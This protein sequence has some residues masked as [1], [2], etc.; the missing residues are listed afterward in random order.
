M[1]HRN[2]IVV[3]NPGKHAWHKGCAS[4]DGT[5]FLQRRGSSGTLEISIPETDGVNG[6]FMEV[7]HVRATVRQYKN[8]EL[9]GSKQVDV[10][11]SQLRTAQ[12]LVDLCNLTYLGNPIKVANFVEGYCHGNGNPDDRFITPVVY[13]SYSDSIRHYPTNI[14]LVAFKHGRFAEIDLEMDQAALQWRTHID[15]ALK[16]GFHECDTRRGDQY[17]K[18]RLAWLIGRYL[19][20]ASPA[21]IRCVLADQN[22]QILQK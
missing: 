8:K 21:D 14:C 12:E 2:A 15:K 3:S 20:K 22:L 4:T 9:V 10:R 16:E 18:S 6:F 11:D 19:I 1:N 5:V 13:C 7:D 17:C